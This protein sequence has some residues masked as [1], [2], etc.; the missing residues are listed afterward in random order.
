MGGTQDRVGDEVL[1]VARRRFGQIRAFAGL[2]A[3]FCIIPFWLMTKPRSAAARIHERAFFSRIVK[4]FGVR[5]E[6]HGQISPEPST[7]FIMNHI[8]WADIP[9]MMAILDADF[10]AKS[11]ML[12]WPVIGALARRFDPVFVARAERHRSHHQADA[13]RD[14]LRSGRSVILCAEGTTSDGST[15]LP[16]R[17][18]LFAAAGAAC[19]V[20]PVVL[21]YLRPDGDA[22][23]PERQ[24]AVAWID[25][26]QLLPGAARVAQ[27]ETLARVELLAP[28]L[29]GG[30]DRKQVADA[31]RQQM[32]AAYA[33]A[34]NRPR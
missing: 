33:T 32:I 31:V 9:V 12:G 15:I 8:S 16:F 21:R 17:T 27:E 7:L 30:G 6:T 25:D 28:T 22:L 14:R 10:V 34:P 19:A 4:S 3:A 24:R 1:A 18:S 20:Q 13:V 2:A 29:P 26:D 11:D 23:A 5:I